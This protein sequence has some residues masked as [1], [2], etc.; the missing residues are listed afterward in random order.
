MSCA[1]AVRNNPDWTS[2][3]G[4]IK[5]KGYCSYCGRTNASLCP[6]NGEWDAVANS[7]GSCAFWAWSDGCDSGNGTVGNSMG[8]VRKPGAAGYLAD[9]TQCCLK[10]TAT[11]DNKTCD[12]QY[13]GVRQSACQ[14]KLNIYC[15]SAN[16]F[17]QPA[18]KTWLQNLAKT[19]PGT[20]NSIA[21]KYCVGN[22]DPFCGCYNVVMPADLKPSATGIYRCLDPECGTNQKALNTLTC[23]DVYQDCSINGVD[24]SLTSSVV[25][26]VTIANN[27]CVGGQCPTSASVP[28]PATAAAPAAAPAAPT[29][30]PV[31][32][33]TIFF[34]VTVV[35]IIVIILV[36]M[37]SASQK[38]TFKKMLAQSRS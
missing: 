20:A 30:P 12:P 35:V 1:T 38:E 13:R 29:K 11:I 10:G 32:K 22:T 4:P 15:D 3:S 8:C 17:L 28:D 33:E 9:P 7:C 24:V 27:C 6:N 19:D 34:V 37:L 16:T 23:P 31:P 25:D 18:C 21:L 26:K 14:S 36:L 5:V 2:A